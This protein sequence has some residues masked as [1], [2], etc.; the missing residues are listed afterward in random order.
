MASRQAPATKAAT[1][2][3]AWVGVRTAVKM[4]RNR[5]ALS[6]SREN[7]VRATPEFSAHSWLPAAQLKNTT[8]T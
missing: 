7:S 1:N 5:I 6:A 8:M 3:I 4:I 2:P